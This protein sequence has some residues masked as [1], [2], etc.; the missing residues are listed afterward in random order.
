MSAWI[1]TAEHTIG[2]A[3]MQM[4]CI[5]AE[6]RNRSNTTSTVGLSPLRLSP[7]CNSDSVP[8]HHRPRSFSFAT[9]SPQPHLLLVPHPHLNHCLLSSPTPSPQPPHTFSFADA[10]KSTLPGYPFRTTYASLSYPQSSSISTATAS[11]TSSLYTPRHATP[12]P[13]PL[14]STRSRGVFTMDK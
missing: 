5:T 13:S 14:A 9:P 10:S 11:L 1:Q 3:P 4:R 12:T 8:P 7:H 6:N 2:Q